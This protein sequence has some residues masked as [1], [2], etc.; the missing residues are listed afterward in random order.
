MLEQI[1]TFLQNIDPVW[2]YII[3][4]FF[5][6]IEN[7]FPPSPSDVVVIIGATLLAKSAPGFLPIVVLT[8]VGSSLGFLTMFLFGRYLGDKLLRSGKLKFLNK[9]DLDK[10]EKWFNKYG[11]TLVVINRFLPGTRAVI[12]FFC[13]MHKLNTYKSLLLAGVSAF[14]WNAFIIFV[15]LKLGENIELIDYYLTTYTN[16]IL[17]ITCIV[18]LFFGIRYFIKKQ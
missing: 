2:I 15:G 8:S 13:G 9:D 3:L 11:Y 6:Y 1:I 7:V 12:S 16:I 4:F 14:L 18:I 10:V 5:A 17:V